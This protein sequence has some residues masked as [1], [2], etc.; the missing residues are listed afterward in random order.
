MEQRRQ[1]RIMQENKV[2]V[3][4]LDQKP[5]L[6]SASSFIALTKDLSLEGAKI[7]TENKLRTGTRLKIELSLE[8]P[9]K[10]IYLNATVK[11]IRNLYD[12]D[13]FEMGIEYVDQQPRKVI[14]L[15]EHLYRK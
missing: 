8:K 11:W 6:P 7:I 12:D 9:H 13:V 14:D 5:E 15:L 3:H 2:T 10:I 4:V 1:K